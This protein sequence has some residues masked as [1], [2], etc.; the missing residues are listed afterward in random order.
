[1]NLRKLSRLVAFGALA[2]LGATGCAN[3]VTDAP[4]TTGSSSLALAVALDADS[5]V[6]GFRFDVHQVSCDGERVVEPLALQV[7]GDLHDFGFPGVVPGL[8]HL[9]GHAF[10]DHYFTLP[11][12]CYDVSVSPIGDD[13]CSAAVQRGV[14]VHDGQTTEILLVSQCAG[15]AVGGLDVI[16]GVNTAPTLVSLE[17]QPSKFVQA[18]TE[19][20]VCATAIDPD[21]DDLA[22][23]WELLGDAALTDDLEVV[24]HDADGD[25]VTECVTLTPAEAAALELRVTVYDLDGDG[26]RFEDA[27]GVDSRDDLVFPIYAAENPDGECDI[28]L[29]PGEDCVPP[30]NAMLRRAGSAI[31]GNCATIVIPE[32]VCPAQI[33][34]WS[35][36]LPSGHV[37]PYEEQFLFDTATGFFGP[38]THELCVEVP[39]CAFQ[40]DLFFGLQLQTN[41]IIDADVFQGGACGFPE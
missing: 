32:G 2:S 3:E 27:L 17:F 26:G 36:G 18:C 28:V 40:I 6:A 16:A 38:G 12:G 31:D 13:D 24:S 37:L 5:D 34:L 23:T 21:G 11:A 29:P 7:E 19:A 22:F 20:T 25:A 14:R 4:S 35:F 33:S 39:D 30:H 9:A 10:A 41:R 8:E 1:M 15:E